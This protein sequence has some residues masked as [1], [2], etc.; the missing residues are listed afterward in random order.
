MGRHG[1]SDAAMRRLEDKYGNYGA[2]AAALNHARRAEVDLAFEWL[3]RAYRQR[4]GNLG[5][6][7]INP[8]L[9]SLH[10]DPRYK[11]LL[12]KLKFPET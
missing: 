5:T 4:E 8:W 6:I 3:E 7:K 2:Y 1:E 12:R 9:R 10:G 11:A